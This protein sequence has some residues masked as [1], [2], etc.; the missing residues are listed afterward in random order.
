[1]SKPLTADAVAVMSVALVLLGLF[2]FF[3]DCE[4]CLC[5]CSPPWHNQM[6]VE[7]LDANERRAFLVWR[8]NLARFV[9]PSRNSTLLMMLTTV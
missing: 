5:D 7:E 8:R 4:S 3:S 1:V 2:F 9:L 6:T